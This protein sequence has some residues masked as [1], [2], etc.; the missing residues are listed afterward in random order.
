MNAVLA[1]LSGLVFGLGLIVS[2]MT[3]PAKVKGFLDLFG[4]W[5]PSLGLV[6]AGAIAVTVIALALARRRSR[7]WSGEPIDLPT[8]TVI[9][10]RLVAGGVLFGIGWGI[11]GFC[12]GPA[13]VTMSSGL[14]AAWI[15]GL[16]MLVGMAV[17]DRLLQPR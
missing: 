13:V 7:S 2:G 14:G 12:P 11:G 1:L 4:A 3:D 16:A 10:R 8:S 9:D 5:N 17:H 6:M 15:F